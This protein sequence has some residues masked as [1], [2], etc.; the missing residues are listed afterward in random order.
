ME[1]EKKFNPGDPVATYESV[2]RVIS[3]LMVIPRNT[4]EIEGD[5]R[6][7]EAADESQGTSNQAEALQMKK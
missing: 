6:R 7:E 5:I 2:E 3:P 4:Q 1:S